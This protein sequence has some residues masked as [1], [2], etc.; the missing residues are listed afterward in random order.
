MKLR[1]LALLLVFSVLPL[2]APLAAQMQGGGLYLNPVAIRITNSV[3]DTGLFAF[4]GQ[5]ATSKMFYGVNLGGYYDWQAKPHWAVGADMRETIVH[6]DNAALDSL[7]F[8]VR[9]VD[10]PFQSPL[11][12]YVEPA[13]G[14][15]RSKS[16]YSTVHHTG[17]ETHIFVGA[18]YPIKKYLDWRV[19][20][21]G[22]GSVGTVNSSDFGYNTSIP[23]SHLLSITT[24]L[25]FR[26]R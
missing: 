4:L 23:S 1:F 12:L 14:P 24:G 25:V 8:G 5:N 21:V 17:L 26:I 15:G 19:A 2:A 13:F 22:Y 11:R 16:P 9:I 6:S 7:L 18:D 20:E 10:K 3:P